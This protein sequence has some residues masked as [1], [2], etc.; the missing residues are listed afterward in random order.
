[1]PLT[2]QKMLQMSYM[3]LLYEYARPEPRLRRLLGHVGIYENAS[4]LCRE[5]EQKDV[6]GLVLEEKGNW[7][8]EGGQ[9]RPVR[10]SSTKIQ[11]ARTFLEPQP[12]IRPKLQDQQ[13]H[14]TI[15]T[16][17]AEVTNGSDDSEDSDSSES[18]D[19]DHGE[20]F[21]RENEHMAIDGD[22]PLKKSSSFTSA[23]DLA[24]QMAKCIDTREVQSEDEQLWEQQQRVFTQRESDQAFYS[25]WL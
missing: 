6:T 22:G 17:I 12:V 7:G 16:E 20:S 24:R 3:E 1:M 13:L 10:R 15:E 19:D 23:S 21:L 14:A 18:S 8:E 4:R 9:P 2:A 5:K 11:F 25:V